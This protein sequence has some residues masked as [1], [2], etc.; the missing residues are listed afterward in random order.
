MFADVYVSSADCSVS[1]LRTE[2]DVWNF[3]SFRIDVSLLF[4]AFPYF[5]FA[6]LY[7]VYYW[8]MA[9]DPS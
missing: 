2:A 5:Y 4:I 1:R 3:Y 6:C 9:I 8:R 7:R